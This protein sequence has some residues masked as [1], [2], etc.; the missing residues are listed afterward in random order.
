MESED[1]MGIKRRVA[2]Q[3]TTELSYR[4]VISHLV[5]LLAPHLPLPTR[6][7]AP[8]HSACETPHSHSR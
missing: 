3:S 5:P 7:R 6:S 2:G 1:Y 4:A 8:H